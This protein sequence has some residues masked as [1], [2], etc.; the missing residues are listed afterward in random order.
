MIATTIPSNRTPAKTGGAGSNPG[1]SV[2]SGYPAGEGWFVGDGGST[3]RVC[4]TLA[5]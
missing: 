1:S 4:P 5:A 3:L 2:S